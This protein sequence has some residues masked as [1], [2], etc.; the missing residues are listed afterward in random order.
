M[1]CDVGKARGVDGAPNTLAAQPY[2]AKRGVAQPASVA[3]ACA[4][5]KY[6]FVPRS[7]T[8]LMP[9][10]SLSSLASSSV[11]PDSALTGASAISCALLPSHALSNLDSSPSMYAPLRMAGRRRA[12]GYHTS[13]RRGRSSRRLAAVTDRALARA[14]VAA[15]AA[16]VGPASAG[17]P[18]LARARGGVPVRRGCA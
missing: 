13:P 10:A 7:R 11:T 15:A 16:S 3:T 8:V 5:R 17:L 4:H 1:R 18:G 9:N 6:L 12:G 2:G 14:G